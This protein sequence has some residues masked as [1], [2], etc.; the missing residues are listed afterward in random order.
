MSDLHHLAN[1]LI[2][3]NDIPKM[4]L[5]HFI[6]AYTNTNNKANDFTKEE[7]SCIQP[8]T[9]FLLLDNI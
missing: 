8:T 5:P 2:N 4:D 3:T 9:Y 1:S 6:N 7:V